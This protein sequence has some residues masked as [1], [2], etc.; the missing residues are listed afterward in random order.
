LLKAWAGGEEGIKAS[1]KV[2]DD[3]KKKAP[4]RSYLQH[5]ISDDALHS[6]IRTVLAP[7]Y[8]TK[9]IVPGN[10]DG[11]K[12]KRKAAPRKSASK[13]T[14]SPSAAGEKMPAAKRRQVS[15]Q[16]IPTTP[17]LIACR[18]CGQTDVPLMMGGRYCRG[19]IDA[20]KA[21]DDVSQVGTST[22]RTS[23]LSGGPARPA[24]SNAS[25]SPHIHAAKDKLNTPPVPIAPPLVT[26]HLRVQ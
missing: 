12:P 16:K 6:Q 1:Q 14:D 8:T 11:T 17:L 2:L 26:T 20:G 25:V 24:S 5:Q 19:C 22:P 18:A 23:Q 10:A 21:V 3:L 15:K 9:S 4:K 13:S 7:S